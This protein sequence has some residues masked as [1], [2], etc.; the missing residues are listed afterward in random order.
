MPAVQVAED[1]GHR[2]GHR[3]R[4]YWGPRTLELRS[5]RDHGVRIGELDP[6]SRNSIA[7]VAGVGVGHVTVHR[8]EPDPPAGRGV[9][10]SGVTAIVPGSPASLLREPL[11]AGVAVLNGAGELTGSLQVREWGVLE[12]PVCLT[13]TMSVGRVYDG[14]VSAAVAADP[15]VGRD[16]VVIP[17]VG[18]C[19]DS[20]PSEARV[21][22]VEA[23]DVARAIAEAERGDAEVAQGAVGAGT[24]MVCFGF[25]GGIGTASRVTQAGTTIG[26]LVLANF[27]DRRELR[28][29]GLAVGRLLDAPGAGPRDPAGSCIAVVATDAALNSAQLERIARRAGLGLARTGSVGHHGSGEIFLAL[30]TIA[31][32][33]RDG[34]P[35]PPALPDA[36]LDPLSPR[37]ST[38]PRRPRSTRCGGP[39]RPPAARAASPTPRPTT[40]ARPARPARAAGAL[41]DQHSQ[42]Y[43]VTLTK[44]PSIS[45]FRGHR[46]PRP[47]SPGGISAVATT[48]PTSPIRSAGG[49]SRSGA[50]RPR[51]WPRPNERSNA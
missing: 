20:W 14:A 1:D 42:G 19:D 51:T 5:P 50:R 25:K 31:R 16:Q 17:V 27:G 7:D 24:G 33:P 28:I 9:A 8:D 47:D 32:E 22:H 11:P 13:A 39:T 2:Q 43:S 49:P 35:A 23:A 34:R 44:W 30:S 3:T 4:P 15:V 6:G 10:R 26:V 37:P 41:S 18:E 36:D 40:S 45:S 46:A 48:R 21:V 38:P 12:T 29:D